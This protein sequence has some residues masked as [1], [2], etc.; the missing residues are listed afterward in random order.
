LSSVDW[1]SDADE[2]QSCSNNFENKLLE[3]VDHLAPLKQYSDKIYKKKSLPQNIKNMINLRKR[4]LRALSNMAT[5]SRF[6]VINKL[7][8][9]YY[10]SIQFNKVRKDVIPGNTQSLWNA[11]RLAKD[12]NINRLPN[13]LFREGVEMADSTQHV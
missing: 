5:K 13:T 4:L 8:R 10:N 3:V 6:N 2:V 11:V 7:I 12:S 9:S 1:S